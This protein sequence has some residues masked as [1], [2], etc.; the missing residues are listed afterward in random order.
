MIIFRDAIRM[1]QANPLGVGPGNFQDIYRRYQT[2]QLNALID[3]AHND[4]LESAAEWGL[5][6]ASIFWTVLMFILFRTV[7]LF[8]SLRS[9]QQNGVAL[10]CIGAIFSILL[11]S[12]ADFNLQI[13]S[14]A[15]LFF[16]LVGIAMALPFRMADD[17][18][19]RIE[20]TL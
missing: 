14:N 18:A 3:H 5:P 17:E 12:L 7:R 6:I 9:S 16:T 8:L 10:A 20:G 4:Y 1:I 15:M 11:H 13:P 19:V 2:F